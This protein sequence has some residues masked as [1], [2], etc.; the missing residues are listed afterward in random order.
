VLLAAG[1]VVADWLVTTD[2]EQ[3]AENITGL[4]RA[5]ESGDAERTLAFISPQARCE[6]TLV[7][8]AIGLVRFEEPLSLKDYQIT[9][10]HEDS[11][12]MSTF[13]AN[14]R[15][16]VRGQ[17]V[18]HQ[19]SMW[20]AIWRKEAGLWKL[21]RIHELDPLH[22]DRVDRLRGIGAQLCD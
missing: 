8:F 11:T 13:R 10:Q 1:A 9:L 17:P 15:V 12:A 21:I 20:Q 6:R 16:L 18:G 3:I 4:V 7:Q 19:A 2:R 22:G 14:G 5:F